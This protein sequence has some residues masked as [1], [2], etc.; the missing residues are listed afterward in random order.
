MTAYIV[1]RLLYAVFTFLGIT[2]VTFTLIH[3]VPGDPIE[4]LASKEMKSVS[5]PRL[6]AALRHEYH[7]DQPLV[8]QYLY[9]FRGIMTLDFGRST[10]DRRL[11][12]DRIAEK[13]PRTFVLNGIAFLLAALIG[14]PVGIWS[15]KHSG[16]LLER[17][18]SVFFFLLYS[19]PT[20]WVA[21][22]LMEWVAVRWNLLPLIGMTSDDYE[23]MTASQQMADRTR[24]FILPVLTLCY[25]QIAVLARYTKSSLTE[26]IRQD[27]ITTARAKGVGEGTVLLVH[28][29]RNA[30]I[31]LVTLLGLIVP[32]LISGSVIVE[33]MFQWDGVGRLYFDAVFARDYPTV[34][35]LSVA[36]AVVT[37]LASL[38]ADILYAFADPRIRVGAKVR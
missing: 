38:A 11:V 32:G 7:L 30:L 5:S 27:F 3:A 36:T 26:V 28:A 15:A 1:R 13:L 22:L 20:F 37:L 21:L 6:V 33:T 23:L 4:F 25:G 14:L 2:V 10:L 31:S 16:R 12:V 17:G 8:V 35:A 29:F 24:H 34:L 19:L 18:S 9:W